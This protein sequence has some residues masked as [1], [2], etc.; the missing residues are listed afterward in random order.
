VENEKSAAG[1]ENHIKSC[2]CFRLFF[3][4]QQ[5][6]WKVVRA[7]RTETVLRETKETKEW[8]QNRNYSRL[9]SSSYI[10]FLCIDM[11]RYVSICIDMYRYVSI[12]IDMYRYVSIGLQVFCREDV[13]TTSVMN[14]VK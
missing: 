4:P 9:M 13:A 12:C 7:R 6:K 2:F 11:Y 8:W 14:I 1:P 5:V 3:Q 10:R